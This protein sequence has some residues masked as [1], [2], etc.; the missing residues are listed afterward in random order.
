MSEQPT[1]A[2]PDHIWVIGVRESD[3]PDRAFWDRKKVDREPVPLDR[4]KDRM[5]EFTNGMQGVIAR[6]E[7]EEGRWRLQEVQVAVEIGAKGSV[8][9]L[10]T[11]GEV[12]GNAGLT[13]TFTRG[14]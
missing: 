9:L 11:G 8:N 13:L 3:H 14:G 1:T 7:A 4:L 2:E 5:A 10:G 12:S 6:V